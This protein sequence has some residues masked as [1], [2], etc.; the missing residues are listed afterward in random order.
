MG[1][2]G[3]T[4]GVE[5]DEVEW[6]VPHR[7]CPCIH[8]IP[9]ETVCPP[10]RVHPT[11]TPPLPCFHSLPRAWRGNRWES[12]PP[13]T[14]QRFPQGSG[15]GLGSSGVATCRPRPR[16]GAGEVDHGLGQHGLPP[17]SQ[18]Q[19]R[20]RAQLLGHIRALHHAHGALSTGSSRPDDA[21][22]FAGHAHARFLRCCGVGGGGVPLGLCSTKSG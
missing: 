13:L 21:H 16:R 3:G 7:P 22:L 10:K 4:V 18:G 12:T 14:E 9:L 1:K 6:L 11:S 17:L 20:L 2:G 15:L 8:R 19:P 5:G